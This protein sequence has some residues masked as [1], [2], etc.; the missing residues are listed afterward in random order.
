MLSSP[1]IRVLGAD[2]S[3]L[4]CLSA[5]SCPL[6]AVSS[7]AVPPSNRLSTC[8]SACSTPT[9]TRSA[10]CSRRWRLV[11]LQP[12][13]LSVC[14]AVRSSTSFYRRAPSQTDGSVDDSVIASLN[15]LV[16]RHKFLVRPS[17]PPALLAPLLRPCLAPPFLARLADPP[18]LSPTFPPNPPPQE[19][20]HGRGSL[21]S[22][23][24]LVK[25]LHE[26][27]PL[28]GKDEFGDYCFALTLPSLHDHPGFRDWR[29]TPL[30]PAESSSSSA[31]P[32]PASHAFR[33]HRTDAHDGVA[34]L[35]AAALAGRPSASA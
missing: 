1:L 27:Q 29:A 10:L 32:L 7:C 23:D 28:C 15:Y 12:R 24:A 26:L 33:P 5:R 3:E 22:V 14:V 25:A 9:G 13:L 16:S 2:A 17:P 31:D 30:P 21:P 4:Q 8:A 34:S 35:S 20:L 18:R 11:S 19:L 6:T